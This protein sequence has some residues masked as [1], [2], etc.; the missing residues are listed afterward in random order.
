MALLLWRACEGSLSNEAG[1]LVKDITMGSISQIVSG[2]RLSFTVPGCEFRRVYLVKGNCSLDY[3]LSDCGRWYLD[4]IEIYS[5]ATVLREKN[6]GKSHELL[7][8]MHSRTRFEDDQN[9][10]SLLILSPMDL[11]S[12]CCRAFDFYP[13]WSNQRH[14]A[15]QDRLTTQLGNDSI[16]ALRAAFDAIF[17]AFDVLSGER[18]YYAARV[19]HHHAVE[20]TA[21]GGSVRRR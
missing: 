21:I 5:A 7:I 18:G 1:A 4:R 2:R 6:I 8:D 14:A 9:G 10:N 17:D 12:L 3:I 20:V 13:G 16:E 11:L 19:L 15:W